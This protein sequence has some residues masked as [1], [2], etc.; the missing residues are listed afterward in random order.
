M[1]KRARPVTSVDL[2][3]PLRV[4]GVGSMVSMSIIGFLRDHGPAKKGEIASALE[5]LPVTVA[6]ALT[7]LLAAD[8]VRSDPPLAEL[9]RGQGAIYRVNNPAVTDLYIQFGQGL[10]EL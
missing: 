7:E 10:R 9:R 6:K 3:G 4:L 2:E 5:L 1:A 8:L